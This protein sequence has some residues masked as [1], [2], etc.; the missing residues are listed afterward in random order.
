[1]PL[2]FA[3]SHGE[4]LPHTAPPRDDGAGGLVSF[5]GCV[6][7]HNHGK[8][9]AHL[10]Y[11][12][13]EN[14]AKAA[15]D[16]MVAEGKKRFGMIAAKACHRLG[17]VE[18]GQPAVFI[19]ALAAHRHEAFLAAR[20]LIDELKKN[21]PI[22]RKEIY[23]DGGFTFDQTNC[24]CLGDDDVARAIFAP[25]ATALKAMGLALS[26]LCHKKVVLV[27]AGGLG[28]P[29]A[30]NLAALDVHLTIVDGD[31][32]AVSNLARQYAYRMSDRGLGK[33]MLLE[34]F[35]T[36]RF[37]AKVLSSACFVDE[38]SM[39]ALSR[40]ADLLVDATDDPATKRMLKRFAHRYRLPFISAS[41]HRRDGEVQ[42]YQPRSAG[43]LFC[44]DRER[45]REQESCA[46]LGV[47]THVC[48]MVAAVATDRALRLLGRSDASEIS[49]ITIVDPA[50]GQS[51]IRIARDP[52]C[53][54][55]GD[56]EPRRKNLVR[57]ERHDR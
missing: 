39:D 46:S 12:A 53:K 31:R 47:L 28:C 3:H 7:Q 18:I 35:I 45:E 34:K 38:A 23:R 9:V 20:F 37:P 32:V 27:G 19:A 49:S 29:L 54:N 40:D 11:E 4:F 6:R 33:A 43:C 22:W 1:M 25:P 36:E 51:T 15:F 56:Q 8:E 50:S 16:E 21:L 2:V 57:I 48:Q 55:C 5:Y 52:R 30:I 17:R 14:L 24:H 10:E 13:H 44:F 26:D 41:V 42:V